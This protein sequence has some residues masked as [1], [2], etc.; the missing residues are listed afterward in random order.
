MTVGEHNVRVKSRTRLM[1]LLCTTL[2]H[3]RKS[4]ESQIK[5]AQFWG[6]HAAW[7]ILHRLMRVYVL[8]NRKRRV[9]FELREDVCRH[10][11]YTTLMGDWLQHCRVNEHIFFT[12][13]KWLNLQLFYR[14]CRRWRG[15][16]K[17]LTVKGKDS[18]P[19]KTIEI[20][21]GF[22]LGEAAA[23]SLTA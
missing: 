22:P 9:T 11:L 5:H 17:C 7:L 4:E 8:W 20:W 23:I 6:S 16:F 3:M 18:L 21:S 1:R 12:L 2:G 13:W 14:N 15:H 19:I 10:H